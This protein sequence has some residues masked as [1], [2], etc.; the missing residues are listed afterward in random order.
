MP[1]RGRG[2]APPARGRGG[3]PPPGPPRGGGPGGGGG[4]NPTNIAS[5][6]QTVGVRRPGF[7][8][9]GRQIKVITNHFPVSIPDAI[10]HHY[11][12]MLLVLGVAAARANALALLVPHSWYAASLF[13]PVDH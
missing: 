12:G 6:V 7:G 10:I 1:P 13:C 2:N 8:R 5:H 4:M 11:D 3:P 9:L